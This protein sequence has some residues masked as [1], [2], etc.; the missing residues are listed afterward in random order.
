MAR[1]GW[2]YASRL[3]FYDDREGRIAELPAHNTA[4][5]PVA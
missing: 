1:T 2:S 3:A 5:A 4:P